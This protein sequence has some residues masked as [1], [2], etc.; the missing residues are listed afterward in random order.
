MKKH[1]IPPKQ[2]IE[3]MK[4]LQ[5]K[6]GKKAI[7]FTKIR[8]EINISNFEIVEAI[9]SNWKKDHI[10]FSLPDERTDGFVLLNPPKDFLPPLK[11]RTKKETEEFLSLK[12]EEK[13]E[14]DNKLE[15]LRMNKMV[16]E[17]MIKILNKN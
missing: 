2:V 17:R 4:A 5:N 11:K 16:V 12:K 14:I 3:T 9:A 7:P 8:E 6:F 15:N 1:K 10:V 13:K